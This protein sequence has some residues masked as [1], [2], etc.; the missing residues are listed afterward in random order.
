[1]KSII[2]KNL[3]FRKYQKSKCKIAEKSNS[4][5]RRVQLSR[6]GY[7]YIESSILKKLGVEISGYSINRFVDQQSSKVQYVCL[8]NRQVWGFIQYLIPPS[9]NIVNSNFYTYYLLLTIGKLWKTCARKFVVHRYILNN[10]QNSQKH[11][12]FKKILRRF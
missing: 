1:M 8:V 5:C 12:F 7:I 6:S 4:A 9:T 2:L 10:Y 3:M 11:N